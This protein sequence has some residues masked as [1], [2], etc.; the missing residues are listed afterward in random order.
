M[1]FSK[2]KEKQIVSHLVF[3]L[4]RKKCDIS[5]YGGKTSHILIKYA[6][7]FRESSRVLMN[8]RLLLVISIFHSVDETCKRAAA[9]SSGKS[10][11]DIFFPDVSMNIDGISKENQPE[12]LHTYMCFFKRGDFFWFTQ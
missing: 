7:V 8:E 3:F 9:E 10:D 11:V 2:K 4:M 6:S 1:D 12:G 5:S